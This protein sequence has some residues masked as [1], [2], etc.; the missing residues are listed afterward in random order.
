MPGRVLRGCRAETRR[1][2]GI[3]KPLRGFLEADKVLG[4][5]VTARGLNTLTVV[6]SEVS[7]S[8]KAAP[9]CCFARQVS[10][11]L[12]RFEAHWRD[13]LFVVACRRKVFGES[14]RI[15]SQQRDV[16][17]QTRDLQVVWATLSAIRVPCFQGPPRCLRIALFLLLPRPR[18]YD[19]PNA[20][21]GFVR[22]AWGGTLAR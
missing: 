18:L 1:A 2:R 8:E 13:R 15:P 14:L 21:S 10:A 16:L 19:G 9:Y 11:G 12:I 20:T 4:R 17:G 5:Q 22:I 6:A 7:L 3:C